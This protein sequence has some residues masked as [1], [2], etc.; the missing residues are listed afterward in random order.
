MAEPATS[1]ETLEFGC[2]LMAHRSK[3]VALTRWM[4]GNRDGADV[5]VRQAMTLLWR[6]RG[7]VVCPD[8]M[9]SRLNDLVRE[10]VRLRALS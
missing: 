1:I 5:V 2:L 7:S 10:G 6:S 4:T 8:E 9:S 3:L